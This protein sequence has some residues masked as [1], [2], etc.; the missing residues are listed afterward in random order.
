MVGQ[1]K[2]LGGSSFKKDFYSDMNEQS[3]STVALNSRDPLA[4]KKLHKI[5]L[6]NQLNGCIYTASKALITYQNAIKASLS[7]QY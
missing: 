2:Y 7:L 1:S 6:Q 5:L 4:S 3:L